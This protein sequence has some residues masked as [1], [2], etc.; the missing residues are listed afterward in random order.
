MCRTLRNCG[1]ELNH[2][3]FDTLQHGVGL[4][5]SELSGGM[6][7]HFAASMAASAR[8]NS[9]RNSPRNL[10]RGSGSRGPARIHP[11]A[12]ARRA[13]SDS[14][15][16]PLASLMAATKAPKKACAKGR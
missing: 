7:R 15:D 2:S 13:R 3:C 11:R 9:S 12:I 6:C 5:G 4:F 14:P 1:T 8:R 10:H 16:D